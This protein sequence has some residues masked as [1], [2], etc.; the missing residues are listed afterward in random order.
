MFIKLLTFS[1]I[2]IA[3]GFAAGCAIWAGMVIARKR[4][5][6]QTIG[7]AGG[8]ESQ[9]SP[10]VDRGDGAVTHRILKGEFE[11]ADSR[12]MAP[13]RRKTGGRE[14]LNFPR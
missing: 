2:W 4:A 14:L 12:K 8:N 9:N 3:I 6:R 1:G 11:N 10:I 7:T 5:A 13:A